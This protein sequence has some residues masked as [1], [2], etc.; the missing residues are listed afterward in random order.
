L[1]YERTNLRYLKRADRLREICGYERMDT[2]G[3]SEYGCRPW[4]LGSVG[5]ARLV[6]GNEY[7]EVT[8]GVDG[9]V[10]RRR[11]A[12]GNE[13]KEVTPDADSEV[14]IRQRTLSKE[15]AGCMRCVTDT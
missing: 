11:L 2:S 4:A 9:E 15:S 7:K 3:N 14:R 1:L 13:Y 8:P 12:G 6:G 5:G 10:K